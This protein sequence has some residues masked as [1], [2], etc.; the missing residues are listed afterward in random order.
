MAI[1]STHK[2]AV[3]VRKNGSY[4]FEVK[5]SNVPELQP[6]DLLVRL[7]VS[8]VCGSDFHLAAGHSGPTRDILG[9]EGVGRVVKIGSAV[10]DSQAHIGDRVGIAWVRDI[11]EK[12]IFC[13]TPGGEGHCLAMLC[14]GLK[15]DGTF[16]EYAIVPSRFIVRI[17]EGVSDHLVAPILCGGVTAYKA[18]KVSGASQ[19]QWVAISG[20]GGGLGSLGVQYAKA[21]GFRV[22][23]IDVGEAKREYSLQMGADAFF[24]GGELD[25]SAVKDLTGGGAA[26]VIVTANAIQAYQAALDLVAPY[27]SYVCVGLT[28]PGKQVGFD[29]ITL[30]SKNIRLMGSA[31]GTREDIWEAIE[32]VARGQVKPKVEMA[33]LEDLPQ[34]SKNFGQVSDEQMRGI[35]FSLL[36]DTNSRDQ[37]LGK[38]VIRHCDEDISA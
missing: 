30:V 17:P 35:P 12:C 7:S 9:H 27:G 19:E 3:V 28:P 6:T 31:V 8:G 29:P 5:T 20:A 18:L 1:P 26:A 16:A 34:I 33:V 38:R 23:A 32:F 14:S 15:R 21:M 25:V 2:V 10:P 36:T 4:D 24:D 13:R 11:C 37:T 22:V